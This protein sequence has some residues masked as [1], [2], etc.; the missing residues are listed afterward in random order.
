[1]RF[2]HLLTRLAGLERGGGYVILEDGT[3]FAPT[4]SGISLMFAQMKLGRDLDREPELADF[5]EEEQKQWQCYAKWTDPDP[6]KHGA[7]SVLLATE[8]KKLCC[9]EGELDE[10]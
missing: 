3:R 4:H 9:S 1:M 5:T 10:K 2:D 6:G 8:G 7:I